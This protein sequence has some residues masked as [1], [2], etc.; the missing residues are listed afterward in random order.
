M[1]HRGGFLPSPL[2]DTDMIEQGNTIVYKNTDGSMMFYWLCIIEATE[3]VFFN[4]YADPYK[5]NSTDYWRMRKAWFEDKVK[6]G[7]IEVYDSLPLDKYGAIF[8]KQA[9]ERNK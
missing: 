6:K 9:I 3:Y 1:Y 4:W 7:V 8:E 5:A 2:K